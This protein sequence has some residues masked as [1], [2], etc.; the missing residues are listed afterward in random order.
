[1]SYL[2]PWTIIG[3][4]GGHSFT[5][6][7]ES[8]GAT[9]KKLWVWVGEWQ[10]RG[11]KVWLTDGRVQE[12][13]K[14]EGGFSQME[15]QDG[16]QIKSLSLWG[17]GAG[18][19]LGAIRIRTTLSQEFFPQ[20][21]KW[22]LKKEY[23]VD[24]GSGI[25][26][27]VVGRGDDDIH[28]LGFLFLNT[29]KSTK[30]INVSYP[31][32]RQEI[33]QMATEEIKAVTYTNNTSVA[34]SYTVESSKTIT[35]KSS[36]SVSNKMEATFSFEVTAGIPELVDASTGFSLTTSTKSSYGLENTDERNEKFTFPVNVPPGK[37]V[38]VKVTIGRAT[39]DL[40]YMGRVKITC[41]NGVTL[42]INISGIYKG[43]TYTNAETI[44]TEK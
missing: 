16:E 11:I 33:P 6:T 18:T 17:N 32:L 25:C 26:L 27:G 9:L 1:M 20:M 2:A 43:V 42:K 13:G 24:V 41:Y 3:G 37:T 12:F 4:H 22:G 10:V 35:K 28:N 19:R 23:P 30:L 21:T 40:P 38:D 5:F 14:P 36:W 29:I 39:M 8:N 7:G 44:V 34:Q 15:F 31:T